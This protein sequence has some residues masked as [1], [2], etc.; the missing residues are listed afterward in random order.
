[1]CVCLPREAPEGAK[2][3]YFASGRDSVNHVRRCEGEIPRWFDKLTRREPRCNES[4]R[5]FAGRGVAERQGGVRGDDHRKQ[6]PNMECLEVIPRLSPP[7]KGTEMWN[8]QILI[9]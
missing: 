5:S 2:W 8:E 1:M 4:S 9:V 7:Y 3:G 6:A